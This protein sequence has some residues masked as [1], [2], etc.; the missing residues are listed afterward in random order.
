MRKIRTNT[1]DKEEEMTRGP[2]VVLEISNLIIK[3]KWRKEYER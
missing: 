3:N 2:P 1:C